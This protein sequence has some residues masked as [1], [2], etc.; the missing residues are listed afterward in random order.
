MRAETQQ[1]GNAN[2]VLCSLAYCVLKGQ[3][4]NRQAHN[5]QEQCSQCVSRLSHQGTVQQIGNKG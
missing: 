4:V 5:K 1:V 2:N 3:L